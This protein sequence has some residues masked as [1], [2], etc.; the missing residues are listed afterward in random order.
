MINNCCVA[1]SDHVSA[2]AIYN[3][4]VEVQ[5]YFNEGFDP[6]EKGQIDKYIVVYP[7]LQ[8]L[9]DDKKFACY[10]IIHSFEEYAEYFLEMD[11]VSSVFHRYN[12][13]IK[14]Y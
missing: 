5:D 9:Y 14:E 13:K 8:E 12:I 4:W 3:N 10:T 6:D 2:Y 1:I 7:S 11:D